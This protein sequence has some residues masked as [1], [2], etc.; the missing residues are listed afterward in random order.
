MYTIERD[1]VRIL[2]Q[3]IC[4]KLYSKDEDRFVE[5][6][7]SQQDLREVIKYNVSFDDSKISHKIQNN[8]SHE[9]STSSSFNI[10]QSVTELS[11]NY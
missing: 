2:Y 7:R 11:S 9:F 8:M 1:I 3:M 10:Y 4:N 6:K 5:N